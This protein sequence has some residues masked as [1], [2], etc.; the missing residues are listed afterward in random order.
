MSRRGFSPTAEQ[1][2]W[3]EAMIAHGIS[4]AAVC[5][6]IKHPQT[7]KP[8]GLKMLRRHFAAEI[9]T[10]AAKAQVLADTRI[11][12]WILGRDGAL[13]DD[14]TRVRLAIFYAKTRMGWTVSKRPKLVSDPIDGE[15]ARRRLNNKIARLARCLKAGETGGS[16]SG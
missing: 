4:E 3:V 1:R 16:S 14:R 10:G 9:A 15:D 7:G 8:I 6:R 2:G 13:L 11:V 5:L 12:D